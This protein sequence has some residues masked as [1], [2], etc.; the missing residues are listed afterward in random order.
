MK[1]TISFYLLFAAVL[2]AAAMASAQ[3]RA[4]IDSHAH[5][6]MPGDRYDLATSAA[7]AVRVMDANGVRATVDFSGGWGEELRKKI[8]FYNQRYPGRFVA[9]V[10]I[11]WNRI[12]E[13]QFPKMAMEIVEQGYQDGARCVKVFKSLG[14]GARDSS[15]K[16]VRVDDPRA[17]TVWEKAAA[18]RMPV[19]IHTGDP[20]AFFRPPTSDNERYGELGVHPEWS[21]Y[22]EKWPAREELLSQLLRVVA[23][24]PATNI[25]GL[26]FGNNPEDIRWVARA[27]ERFPNYGL[28]T[29]A[30]IGEIGRHDPQEL[31]ALFIRF[32]DRITFGTDAAY[33]GDHLT[34]GVPEPRSK[35]L[36]ESR[37][38]FRRHWEF[39]ETGH[40]GI[41]HPSPIQG[42]WKV[43]AIN[44][45]PEVLRKIYRE[46]AQRLI[47]ALK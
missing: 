41:E 8:A 44:L 21:F 22:G 19:F 15:G 31:R 30:R 12:D 18:L 38:F 32:Q 45:P 40:R 35:T 34:L 23:H 7:L 29:G 4:V 36:E 43:N 47:P 39:L 27:M 17:D 42:N 33:S 9:C 20:A 16:L 11:P 24:H 13:P 37:E 1:R 3:T 25:V 46:N 14:L 10:N 26:H 2:S 6:G 5:I 28:D